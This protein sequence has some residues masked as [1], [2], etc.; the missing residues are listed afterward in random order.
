MSL[1]RARK[2][3]HTIVT[4][5]LLGTTEKPT[6]DCAAQVTNSEIP[7]ARRNHLLIAR[8]AEIKSKTG[9]DAFSW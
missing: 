8:Q 4:R 9:L 3:L 6:R 7:R 5:K 1:V 2:A